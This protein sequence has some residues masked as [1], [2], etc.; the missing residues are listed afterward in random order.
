MVLSKGGTYEVPS[1]VIQGLLEIT[2]SETI[3]INT[4]G[5]YIGAG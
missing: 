1:L 2:G 3:T 5:I 4:K